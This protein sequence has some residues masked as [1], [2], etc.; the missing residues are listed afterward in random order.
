MKTIF[1]IE[2]SKTLLMCLKQSLMDNGYR[3]ET[4]ENG[5]IAID[6]VKSGL[7]PDLII[8]DIN[9]PEM[10][11]LEFIRQARQVLRFTPILTLTTET[12]QAKRDQARQL[13]ATGWLVKPISSPSLLKVIEK[14]LPDLQR[15]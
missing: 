10:D 8:T 9:M 13:G 2:D 5:K 1:L 4:A 14:V 7:K 15:A 11:G 12:Q 3:V 6:K